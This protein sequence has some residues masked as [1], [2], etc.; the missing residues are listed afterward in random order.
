MSTH[1]LSQEI[2]PD[3][4]ALLKQLLGRCGPEIT[5]R[6]MM[7]ICDDH[8]SQTAPINVHEAKYWLRIWMELEYV[9][10][11]VQEIRR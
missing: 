7:T 9:V 1:A 2:H 11:A 4:L 8:I 10:R 6:A 5:L 3:E